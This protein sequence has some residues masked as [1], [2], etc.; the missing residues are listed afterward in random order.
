MVNFVVGTY[1]A[2]FVPPTVFSNTANSNI[3]LSVITKCLDIL[4]SLYYYD[5]A[6]SEQKI[7]IYLKFIA[8]KQENS[9][10]RKCDIQYW[11]LLMHICGERKELWILHGRQ[12]LESIY[13]C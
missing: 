1:S 7:Y 9:F 11:V 5:S 12:I 3:N 8:N 2:Q 6:C 13:L 10:W 4:L